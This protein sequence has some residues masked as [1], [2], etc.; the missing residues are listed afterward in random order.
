MMVSDALIIVGKA[1]K[2]GGLIRSS[3][4]CLLYRVSQTFEFGFYIGH[5]VIVT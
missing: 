5:K 4:I 2:N 3:S 1:F